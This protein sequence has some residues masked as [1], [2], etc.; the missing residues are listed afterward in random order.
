ME[1]K[2]EMTKDIEY[3]LSKAKNSI[4]LSLDQKNPLLCL[5]S[6]RQAEIA[7]RSHLIHI[8]SGSDPV[9]ASS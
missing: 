3:F 9:S 2:I 6:I 1:E 5:S 7:I 4:D 8:Q